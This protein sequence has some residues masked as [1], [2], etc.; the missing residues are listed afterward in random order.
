MQHLTASLPCPQPPAWAVLERELLARMSAAVEPYLAR[1]TRPDGSL[2]LGTTAEQHGRDDVDDFY[3]AF[4]NWPLLYAL[5]GPAR[6]LELSLR[7]YDA[8]TRQ[9]SAMGLLEREFERGTDQFHQGESLIYFYFLCLADPSNPRLRELSQRFAG[10]YTGEDPQAPNYDRERRIIRAPHNGSLGPRWGYADGDPAAAVLGWPEGMN[11]FGLPFTDLPGIS[12]WAEMRT[13]KG[14]RAMGAAIQSRYGRGDVAANLGVTSLVT[15]AYLM[16]GDERYRDWVLE[17]VDAWQERAAQ[18]G[19]L[20]PDNVD[21]N[22]VVG[23]DFEGRPY[24]GLYGWSWPH[25]FYNIGMSA[26]IAATNAYLLSRDARYLDLARWQLDGVMAQARVR[27]NDAGQAQLVTNYRRNDAGWFDEQAL[28]ATLP[29]ALW[30]VSMSEADRERLKRLSAVNPAAWRELQPGRGK[31]DAGHESAWLSFLDGENPGYPEALLRQSLGLL[32]RRAQLLR[33]DDSDL[34]H[35]GGRNVHLLIHTW[36]Q[37]N[38][39]S[40]EALVQLTLGAP[41]FVYNGGLLHARLRYFDAERRRPGLPE[42]V[43]ALVSALNP[44]SVQVTLV[45]LNPLETRELIL[46]AGTF[47]EHEFESVRFEERVSD[48]PGSIWTASAPTLETRP[49]ELPVNAR[50]LRVTLPPGSWVTLDLATRLHV[51]PPAYSPP[52]FD[53]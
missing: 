50:H 40:T 49:S 37:L 23:G 15:N 31:E 43:S 6:L 28:P 20:L 3:E 48:Y 45:N 16:T 19:G 24:G 22:G 47:G 25:G 1:F 9:L 5:G 10:F 17:Y 34:E 53:A 4:Y 51:N 46:Q 35:P 32:Y 27:L 33:E 14:A 42:D 21:L 7:E 11:I 39:V 26:T 36:Q 2:I 29:V 52:D 18:A 12:S 41:Q 13:L 38:P 30:N 44:G 8:V